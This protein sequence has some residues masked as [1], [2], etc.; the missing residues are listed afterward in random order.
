MLPS[1]S[2][3]YTGT[4]RTMTSGIVVTAEVD[5]ES[6]V[7]TNWKDYRVTYKNNINVGTAS[8]IVEGKGNYTGKIT[9]K[10]KITAVKL[11]SASLKY[12]YK[13]YT[14]TARTMDG[15]T[16]VKA[17][18][19]G[20]VKTLKKGTDYTISYK[21]NIKAGICRVHHEKRWAGRSTSWNQD[22][23]EKYQ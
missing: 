19:N 6:K 2:K 5:G 11:K 15:T 17:E 7:L 18:V 4:E 13:V 21:N 22:S 8:A 12:T 16:T 3:K 9:K 20:K 14:G 10:F 23:R 1:A